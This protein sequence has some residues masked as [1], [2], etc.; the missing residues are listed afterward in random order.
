MED[1]YALA[2]ASLRARLPSGLLERARR[3]RAFMADTLGIELSEDVL[4]LSNLAGIMPL[5]MMHPQV[6]AS[7]R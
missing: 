5:W 4:P 3:R 7:A 6:V 1:G 2:D